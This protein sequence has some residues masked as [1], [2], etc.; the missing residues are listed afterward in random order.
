MEE[1]L[2]LLGL[3]DSDI[4]VYLAL[5]EIGESVASKIAEKANVP[6]SSIY[7]ILNRLVKEGMISHV[8][9]DYLRY[10]NA[11]DPKV[12]AENLEYK[13]NRIDDILPN[14]EKIRNKSSEKIKTEVFDGPKGIESVFN[15]ML[16]E[17]EI[18]TLG[19]S[20]KTSEVLP[21][22]MPKWNRQRKNKNLLVRIIYLDTEDNRQRVKHVE[23]DLQPIKYKF[24][25]TNYLFPVMTF[26]FGNKVM[27]GLFHKEPSATVI[28]SSEL[29]STYR[30][31]F[32]NLWKIAKK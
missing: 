18:L 20:G 23:K 26:V 21:Y 17:K 19:G 11:I 29:A 9:K 12:I 22:F 4:K 27:F 14:L 6:R 1:E 31:Y 7:D 2:K 25:Q 8:T 24:L 13:K 15:M 3:N 10:F 16:K 32:E 5:L 28:E 30:G